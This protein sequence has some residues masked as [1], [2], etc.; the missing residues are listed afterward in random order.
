M[1]LV[2]HGPC[3]SF[4][5]AELLSPAFQNRTVRW[6]WQAGDRAP[7]SGDTVAPEMLDGSGERVACCQSPPLPR[8]QGCRRSQGKTRFEMWLLPSPGR[9]APLPMSFPPLPVGGGDRTVR[10][11]ETSP[12]GAGRN[13]R[14]RRGAP[15]RMAAR[16]ASRGTGRWKQLTRLA[17]LRGGR[18][19]EA[20]SRAASPSRMRS[21][22]TSNSLP[23]S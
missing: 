12:P 10:L 8:R 3:F 19:Q 11:H 7:V 9:G 14:R 23:K 20:A 22:P 5:R 6:D 16:P 1:I 4:Q 13:P 18:R 2:R 17:T 21:S 15:L